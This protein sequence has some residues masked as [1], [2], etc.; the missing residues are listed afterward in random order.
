MTKDQR[1]IEFCVTKGIIKPYRTDDNGT[2]VYSGGGYFA[3]CNG[4]QFDY[5]SLWLAKSHNINSDLH[6]VEFIHVG[7]LQII[8]EDEN[9]DDDEE[10]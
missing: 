4:E 1:F 3:E 5:Y 6:M 10:E 7:K 8:S 9:G 2:T